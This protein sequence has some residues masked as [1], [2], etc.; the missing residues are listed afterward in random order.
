MWLKHYHYDVFEPFK[1]TETGID[2]TDSGPLRFN[3]ITNNAGEIS[4]FKGKIEPALPDPIEFKRKPNTIEV[5][6]TTLEKYIGEYELAG[7]TIKFY[8][9]NDK[10][11]FLFV[12][13]QPEYEL[14][15]TA[16]HKFALKILEGFK[17]EFFE[18]DKGLINEVLMIQPNDS[19]KAKRKTE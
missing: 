7:T 6:K 10:T 17:V 8:I 15:A 19:F 18:D 16:K 13:G 1:V 9:K 3:F 14:L 2:S 11:L 5:D 12:A 4:G